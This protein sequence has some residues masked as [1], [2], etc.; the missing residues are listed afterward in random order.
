MGP[1]VVRK[2]CQIF[3]R[4]MQIC[5]NTICA[6]PLAFQSRGLLRHIA[7]CD[8]DNGATRRAARSGSG[9]NAAWACRCVG[10]VP[11]KCLLLWWRLVSL[12]NL[13]RPDTWR[14]RPK[15]YVISISCDFQNNRSV[16]RDVYHSWRVRRRTFHVCSTYVSYFQHF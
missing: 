10:R 8:D 9:V 15:H 1:H 6:V 12:E 16:K 7:D 11:F 4:R 14:I 2:K 3:S 5:P 13:F